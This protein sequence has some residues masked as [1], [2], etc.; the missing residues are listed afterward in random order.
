MN[1]IIH[2][3]LY[4]N[5]KDRFN[6]LDL[7]H[8]IPLFDSFY[9]SFFNHIHRLNPTQGSSGAIERFEP[10]HRSHNP[11]DDSVILLNYVIQILALS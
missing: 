11:L 1:C 6:K 9:L 3:A 10:R 5:T 4:G 7:S 2:V 8:T